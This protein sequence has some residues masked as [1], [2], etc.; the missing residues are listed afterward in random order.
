MFWRQ[1][2]QAGNCS[3]SIFLQ[4]G[5][6]GEVG[7]A[8]PPGELPKGRVSVHLAEPAQPRL[9]APPPAPRHLKQYTAPNVSMLACRIKYN[10]SNVIFKTFQSSPSQT[11]LAYLSL[12]LTPHSILKNPK[13]S[14]CDAIT[15]SLGMPFSLSLPGEPRVILHSPG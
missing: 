9:P 13:C 2:T 15:P 11:P 5:S 12:L 6:A 14:V 4:E 3:N 8:P 7:A 10:L 1:D